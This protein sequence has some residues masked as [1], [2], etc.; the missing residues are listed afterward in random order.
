[1]IVAQATDI[2]AGIDNDN[3]LRFEKAVAWLGELR[4]DY[5]VISGDLVDDGWIEGH[6]RLGKMLKLLPFRTFVIPGNS[7]DKNAMRSALPGF[8][9]SNVAGPLHF[10]EY[11]DDVLLLGLDATVDGAAY[12]DVTDHLPW[13]RRKLEAFPIGTAM[14]FIHHH[15]FPSG[16][17]LI[18]EVMCRGI[19][20][21]AE[22]LELHGH[23][24]EREKP[25]GHAARFSFAFLSRPSATA[26]RT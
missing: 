11:C 9:G 18:D 21:L 17:R 19:D 25:G 13:L 26:A 20:E 8:I 12:G 14:L 1:M 10:T 23:R 16:I 24:R 5:V 6:N 7:D 4:P 15:I 2:H 22:L 3:F